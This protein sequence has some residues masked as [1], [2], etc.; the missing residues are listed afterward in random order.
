[1]RREAGFTLVELLITMVIIGFVL[2]GVTQTFTGILTQF[3][4]QSKIA[5]T[6][7]EGIV[8][9]ELLR[10]DIENAGYGLP[11]KPDTMPSYLE[12]S[13]GYNDAP[14]N[15]PRAFVSG[16]GSGWNNSDVLIVKATNVAR[17]NTAQKWTYINTANTAKNWGVAAENLAS[18]DRVIVIEPGN[19]DGNRRT[20]VTNSTGTS[21]WRTT[22]GATANFVPG[23]GYNFVYGVDGDTNLRMPFNRADY[24]LVDPANTTTRPAR[25]AP[26]ASVLFKNVIS[27]NTGAR[28][29]PLPLLDCVADM[30]VVFRLDRDGDGTA[31]SPTDVLNDPLGTALTAEQVRNQLKEVRVYILAQE[32]Q[33]DRNYAYVN[34]STFTGCTSSTQFYVGDTSIGNG[35]CFDVGAN[36]HYRWKLYTLV[37]KP[38]NLK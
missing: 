13:A 17:N 5:E 38:S 28:A 16:S 23:S 3:K 6:N 1:M 12:A 33:M 20:L 30:Q 15:P 27:Q 7:I 32:G 2:A 26:N 10:Q 19:A 4:Q 21:E 11:W 37:V 25:C 18:A 22:F 14:T 35:R 31:E 24:Y 9:L 34:S 8:G 36:I 29:D